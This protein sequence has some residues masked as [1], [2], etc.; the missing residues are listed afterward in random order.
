M[1]LYFLVPFGIGTNN[2]DERPGHPIEESKS[3]LLAQLQECLGCGLEIN[4]CNYL[5][6]KIGK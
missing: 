3:F 5:N 6:S 2:L 4:F 1:Q